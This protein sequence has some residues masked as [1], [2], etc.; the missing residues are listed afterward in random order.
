LRVDSISNFSFICLGDENLFDRPLDDDGHPRPFHKFYFVGSLIG[1]SKYPIALCEF[2]NTLCFSALLILDLSLKFGPLARSSPL[3]LVSVLPPLP[4]FSQRSPDPTKPESFPEYTKDDPV[5]LVDCGTY[6]E[7]PIPFAPGLSCVSSHFGLY[8]CVNPSSDRPVLAIYAI[9]SLLKDNFSDPIY[10]HD[11]WSLDPEISVTC[12]SFVHRENA[13]AIAL[14]TT[15]GIFVVQ[16][17]DFSVISSVSVPT[18]VSS[19]LCPTF[20][21]QAFI[22]ILCGDQLYELG[23]AL[24]LALVFHIFVRSMIRRFVL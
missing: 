1:E 15:N 20:R 13:C 10:S 14:G 22:Y 18:R 24:S 17:L 9:A 11:L 16:L 3:S 2:E 21:D 5:A 8:A 23:N 6:Q 4:S 7:C 12:T 19:I